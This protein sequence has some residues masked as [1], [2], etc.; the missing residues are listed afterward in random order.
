MSQSSSGSNTWSNHPVNPSG[1]WV[2]NIFVSAVLSVLGCLSVRTISSCSAIVL[3]PCWAIRLHVDIFVWR[4]PSERSVNLRYRIARGGVEASSSMWRD[5]CKGRRG[6]CW[7]STPLVWLFVSLGWRLVGAEEGVNALQRRLQI[8][9][10]SSSTPLF[11][12]SE[13]PRSCRRSLRISEHL[14]WRGSWD[15]RLASPAPDTHTLLHPPCSA[16][17]QPH[18]TKA[19]HFALPNCRSPLVWL[20]RT[21]IFILGRAVALVLAGVRPPLPLLLCHITRTDEKWMKLLS[22]C[23]PT[24]CSW[25]LSA[26]SFSAVLTAT[27]CANLTSWTFPPCNSVRYAGGRW[28]QGGRTLKE[29]CVVYPI[30]YPICF[31]VFFFFF[32]ELFSSQYFLWQDPH[33]WKVSQ[34]GIKLHW[35]APHWLHI[36]PLI[37]YAY[38]KHNLLHIYQSPHFSP[39]FPVNTKGRAVLSID[40]HHRWKQRR[41]EN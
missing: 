33:S 17:I 19:F 5:R 22:L 21:L 11:F 23:S 3:P 14:S 35:A 31:L 28:R 27:V 34:R 9:A 38:Q 40:G 2:I 24:F 12:L 15:T 8:K 32:K 36:A 30:H 13:A 7:L 20:Q 39:L 18:Y 25:V 29:V 1:P 6:G 4:V 26:V 16:S 41:E 37:M 10:S